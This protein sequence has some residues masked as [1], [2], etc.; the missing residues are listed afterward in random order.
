MKWF[1]NFSPSLKSCAVSES[2]SP[3][4]SLAVKSGEVVNCL[5]QKKAHKPTAEPNAAKIG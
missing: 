1:L 2:L 4:A 3:F 5:V